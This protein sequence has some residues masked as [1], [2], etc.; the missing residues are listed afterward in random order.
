MYSMDR[1]HPMKSE[2]HRL[3]EERVARA[4]R[5]FS[6]EN[7]IKSVAATYRIP[8]DVLIGPLRTADVAVARWHVY[9]LLYSFRLELTLQAVGA[10]L[11]KHHTTILHGVNEFEKRRKKYKFMIDKVI[12]HLEELTGERISEVDSTPQARKEIVSE[13]EN[14]TPQ[15]EDEAITAQSRSR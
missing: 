11:D 5:I 7:C 4:A 15:G 9:W 2:Q 3:A 10:M 12:K 13:T 8:T 14:A 6:L 1:Q